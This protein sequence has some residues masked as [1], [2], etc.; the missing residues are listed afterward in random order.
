MDFVLKLL[1]ERNLI[2]ASVFPHNKKGVCYLTCY[3]LKLL[4]KFKKVKL[5]SVETIL[6]AAGSIVVEASAQP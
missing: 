6:D 1:I 5:T 4:N 3:F 2:L